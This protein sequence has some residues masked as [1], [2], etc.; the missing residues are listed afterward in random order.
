VAR[1]RE[2]RPTY[3]VRCGRQRRP[4][5]FACPGTPVA[6]CG[7]TF[8]GREVPG[9]ARPSPTSGPLAGA[10][11]GLLE[12]PPGAVALLHGPKG[13]GKTSIALTALTEPWVSSSE[14]APG[15][16]LAY[17]ARMG[18]RLAGV[19][20]PELLEPRPLE[21][22]PVR[23][24]VPRRHAA[25]DVLLDSVT[26]CGD[27]LGALRALEAHCKA[28]GARGIAIAQHTK[29]G[30]VKGP[31]ALE[32]DC[33]AIVEVQRGRLN[34]TKNRFGREDS[35]LFA[36]EEA[37]AALPT[38]DRYYSI[39][40][41]GPNYRIVPWPSSPGARF[42]EPY[43]AATAG[44]LELPEPPIAVAAEHSRVYG[45]WIAPPDV[46][47]RKQFAASNGLTFWEP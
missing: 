24:H 15:M 44:K 7:G 9:T 5:E 32:Y 40:G 34:V 12:L 43:R 23:L 17:A 27:A 38:W 22:P 21:G 37:G 20:T 6:P 16:V 10:L 29:E 4:S 3:C 41:D 39:E 36:L 45:G 46:A 33:D 25:G 8:Y 30:D 19:S 28:T 18:V 2:N 11:A 35:R 31:A 13:A 42:A 26:R 47:Q 14:M 1:L